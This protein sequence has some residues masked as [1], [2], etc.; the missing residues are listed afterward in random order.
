MIFFLF[1]VLLAIPISYPLKIIPIPRL[2]LVYSILAGSV[3]IFF[4]FRLGSAS[5]F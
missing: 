4:I 3:L 5:P 1:G 2:R